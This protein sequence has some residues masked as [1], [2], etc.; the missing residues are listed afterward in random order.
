MALCS[1]AKSV[2]SI[3]TPTHQLRI[4]PLSS[5]PLAPEREG[6]VV[7]EAEV[8]VD[9]APQA[10]LGGLVAAVELRAVPPVGDLVDVGHGRRLAGLPTGRVGLGPADEHPL[11]TEAEPG[12][13]VLVEGDLDDLLAGASRRG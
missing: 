13:I 1:R 8:A 6:A 11:L 9:A 2:C 3:A 4:I 5:T 7:G 10:V 12:G